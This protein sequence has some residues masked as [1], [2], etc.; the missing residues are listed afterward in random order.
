MKTIKELKNNLSVLQRGCSSQFDEIILELN[1][2]IN[3]LEG[4]RNRYECDIKPL[5]GDEE[6]EK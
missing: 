1:K 3:E 5:E 6:H 4:Y 2:A